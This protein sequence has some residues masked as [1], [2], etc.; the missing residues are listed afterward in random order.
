MEVEIKIDESCP[1]PKL[2][3]VTPRLTEEVEHLAGML[4]AGGPQRMVAGFRGDSAVL[5]ETEHITRICAG[6]GKVFAVTDTGEYTLRAR[7]YELE[8]RLDPGQFVRISNSELIN[9]RR[10]R[11]FDLSLSGT[12]CVTFLDGTATYAS[13]RY[14]SRL[15]H[16]LGI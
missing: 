1:S 9:L 3:I 5:L 10:V 6:R 13:R 7:L 8:A 16:V 12:I 14:V 4:S 11:K 2:I 15:K